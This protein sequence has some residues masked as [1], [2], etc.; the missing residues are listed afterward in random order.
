MPQKIHASNHL[1]IGVSISSENASSHW[2]SFDIPFTMIHFSQ[3]QLIQSS[4]DAEKLLTLLS[5]SLH[6]CGPNS[7]KDH[8]S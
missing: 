3:N 1:S 2:L 7:G 8:S 4:P 6:F 5:M